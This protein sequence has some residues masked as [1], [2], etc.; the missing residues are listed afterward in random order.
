MLLLCMTL[1]R[2]AEEKPSEMWI[3]V[4]PTWLFLT[5]AA[6][7]MIAWWWPAILLNR[8]I[9]PD[10]SMYLAAAHLAAIRPVPWLDFD[11]TTSGPFVVWPLTLL[12]L[13]GVGLTY[14]AARWTAVAMLFMSAV[15]L[16]YAARW[17][18]G[19]T[20]AR[21]GLFC[22]I[23][24]FA[25]A[26]YET[27]FA[28]YSSE[29]VPVLL[30][31]LLALTIAG[32]Y[33]TRGRVIVGFAAAG[34]LAGAIPLAKLQAVPIDA[35]LVVVVVATALAS[36]VPFHQK[37]LRVA[38]FTACAFTVLFVVMAPVAISGAWN[39]FLISYI[40]EPLWYT[41]AG[42]APL[43]GWS[44][45]PNPLYHPSFFFLL[46]FLTSLIAVMLGLSIARRPEP[47]HEAIRNSV[48]FSGAA[49]FT[50][51][52]AAYAVLKPDEP[53]GVHLLFL[54]LPICALG[55]SSLAMM[56][57]ASSRPARGRL[58]AAAFVAMLAFS[59]AGV[60]IKDGNELLRALADPAHA[61]Y[62]WIVGST[63]TA[64]ALAMIE[65]IPA[66]ASLTVWGWAPDAYVLSGATMG[67]RDTITQFQMW[68]GHYQSYY[69]S[70]YIG[71]LRRNRPEYVLDAVSPYESTSWT[72]P[73]YQLKYFKQL[74]MTVREHYQLIGRTRH[75]RL[76]RQ[77]PSCFGMRW[78]T[79]QES[80][81]Q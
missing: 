81:R 68:P 28:Y 59:S 17:V 12:H 15:F 49:G 70:R 42:H 43:P 79:P 80:I 73:R 31:A 58:A 16:Y 60:A 64:D 35:A 4:T 26:S 32:I 46:V 18:L 52:A 41:T 9:N 65:S 25:T 72:V 6:A 63:R 51:A 36:P 39:D 14:A 71:D 53:W 77:V 3:R 13:V 33:V 10:E 76:Y 5:A 2:V 45:Q 50:L 78:E 21:L 61:R 57:A 34:L 11:T 55:A 23:V 56:I 29:I 22:A 44:G 24:V 27:D 1:A 69:L 48:L 20:A 74:E 54:V 66:N 38:M 47:A 30:T 19:E 8:Q 62:S 37:L 75:L 67:T 40:R 7:T